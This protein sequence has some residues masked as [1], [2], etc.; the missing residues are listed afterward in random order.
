MC[1]KT[2][3]LLFFFFIEKYTKIIRDNTSV[4]RKSGK[5][6]RSASESQPYSRIIKYYRFIGKN[7]F[8]R[9]DVLDR[10][11]LKTKTRARILLLFR[12]ERF[13]VSS[14]TFYAIALPINYWRV[15]KKIKMS[16]NNGWSVS[17]VR[18]K[19][20]WKPS[21]HVWTNPRFRSR[22]QRNPAGPGRS[23]GCLVRMGK[24]RA[25]SIPRPVFLMLFDITMNTK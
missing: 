14:S 17:T 5:I 18:M 15:W 7:R 12:F 13:S 3:Q 24:V 1:K 2:N 16:S 21:D 9:R 20:S 10:F 6:V 8:L 25:R 22:L 23:D 4:T 19:M 11:I